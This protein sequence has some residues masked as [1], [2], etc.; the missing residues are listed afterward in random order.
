[1]NSLRVLKT[2]FLDD[3]S[4]DEILT[5]VEKDKIFGDIPSVLQAS[6]QFLAELETVWRQDPMLHDLPNV[7]LKYADRCLDIYVTYCSNQVSIDTTLR[8]LR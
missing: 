8:D 3:S 5:S 7:L 2:E 1:M 4:I 6:E